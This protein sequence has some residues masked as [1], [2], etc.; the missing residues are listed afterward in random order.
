MTAIL[1]IAIRY[2]QDVVLTRQRT[3]QIAALLGFDSQD[4]ARIATAVSEIARNAFQYA[5][6]G[7][8]E[9][10]VEGESPQIFAISIR[11]KGVGIQNL[12]N[13]LNGEYTST[14]GMGVGIRGSQRLMDRFDIESSLGQ[15]TTVTMGK[16]LPKRSPKVTASRLV[17]IA[18][19]LVKRL[20]QNPFEEIQQQ[21]QELLRALEELR[22]RE[23]QLTQLNRELEDTNRGVVALYAELDEKATSL[24]KAN[25]LKTRFLSNMS[26]EFRTPV[27]S[28][29]SLSGLLLDRLDGDLTSEQEKQVTFIRKSAESLSDL[30]NDLLDLAKV[31]AG[32]VEVRPQQ[33]DVSEL[34]GTL[35]G[36]LRPLLAHNSSITLV[37]EEP[38][39]I[40]TLYTD[41]GKVAQ[42]L[43]NFISNALKYTEKGE[44]RVA[45]SASILKSD[46]I[47]FSVADTGIGIAAVDQERIF[48][49]FVQLDSQLQ[50]KVK[51]TGLGLPLSRKLAELL[52]G[53]VSL[54]SELGVGSTFYATIPIVYPNAADTPV[55]P[56][57]RELDSTRA[58]V[59]V[60][61]DHA[62]ILLTYEKYLAKS[63]YQIIPAR[64]L[65]QARQA[66]EIVKPIAI[67]LDILLEQEHAW[68]FI[69]ELKGNPA[70]QPIPILVATV[71]NNE[72]QAMALGADGFLIKPVDRLSFVSKLNTLVKRDKPQTLLL[73]DDDLVARYVLKQLLADT[74]LKIIEAA[75]GR[76]G[77]RLA[78]SAN[79]AC[80]V[81]DLV[82]PEMDGIE[83][84][85][86]LKSDPVT[87][88]IPVIVNT[89]K[90]L[91]GEEERLLANSTVAILSK[92]NSFQD[93]ALG[94]AQAKRVAKLREALI[95][96]GLIL[97]VCGKSHD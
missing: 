67:I 63:I 91:E 51:G 54:N 27:N 68:S 82:M 93:V 66:L 43:R 84:L 1:T 2:E 6:G 75:D 32:K 52:G 35:R 8:V 23:E 55:P 45:A 7:K 17:E 71:I 73:I 83:V 77:I 46:S 10:R 36:M 97:K 39:G 80:I 50:R 13:I 95:Q 19:E 47:T 76:E 20:P 96:A 18:D 92:E 64:S 86:Q 94:E 26:H 33:F 14:T 79:P 44:V 11:D 12:K 74:G 34:F 90:Q 78:K 16:I 25:E 87:R 37:F 42:I 48:E 28:I 38:I 29:I 41:E 15:G 88:P 89:S 3:R 60:V 49:E 59:L 85:N 58:P 9:F 57:Y 31:E 30:V 56:V 53:S 72:K 40:P 81:L 21:N 69:S 4:Q 22:K 5:K 24:Q 70:T 65:E 62:E 61:E